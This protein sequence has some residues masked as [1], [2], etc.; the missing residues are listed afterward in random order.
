RP[1]SPPHPAPFFLRRTRYS[2][3]DLSD[4]RQSDEPRRS[5]SQT[6]IPRVYEELKRLATYKISNDAPNQTLSGTALLHEAYLRLQKEG[7]GPKWASE[8]QFFSA[9]AE[10][11]RRILIDRIRAKRRIKRGGDQIRTEFIEDSLESPHPDDQLMQ[12]NEAL[13]ELQKH[14]PAAADLVKLRFF[15]GLTTTEIADATGVS[16]RTVSR[17][18]AFAKAWLGRKLSLPE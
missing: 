1:G 3:S 10:A 13:D 9:A 2:P 14:D 6:L 7:D 11:M 12:I 18:W 15:A 8:K 17:Q 5:S 4:E 16:E